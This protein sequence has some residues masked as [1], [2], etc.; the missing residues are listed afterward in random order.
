MSALDLTARD[1]A[2]AVRRGEVTPAAVAADT[3]ARAAERNPAINAICHMNPEFEAEAERVTQRL[4]AGEDPPLAGVP[5]LIKD[6]IWVKGLRVSQGSR[7]FADHIA[8]EDADSVRRLRNAG[9][10][11]LG[12]ATCSEF[13]CKGAT[14]SPHHGITRNPVDLTLGPGGSS[15]GSV[16][17]VAAGIVPLALGTDAGGSSRR[18]PAHTGL[19]GMKPTYD[20]I[21]YGPSFPEPVWGISVI[22][23]IARDMGDI[24]LAMEVMAGVRAETPAMLHIAASPDFGTGQV[25]EPDVAQNFAT[26]IAAFAKAGITVRPAEIDWGGIMGHDI[27]PLQ[28]AGLAQAYGDVWRDTPEIFDP[29]IAKQIETGLSLSGVDVARAHQTSYK[30]R[31]VLRAALDR[32]GIIATP[33]TPCPAWPADLSAPETI[34]GKPAGPRDHAA[35]TPQ[36]NH[37]GVPAL[38]LP[39]GTDRNG[40]PL[41]LQLIAPAGEDGALI[42]AALALEP[43]LKDIA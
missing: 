14:N 34:A 38:S 42:G 20:L 28:F 22:C 13:A 11:I 26:V 10:M 27:L 30:M 15:G 39:C 12:I 6:N 16:A 19:C 43:L 7:L 4:A 35:F 21:P 8:P 25:V 32:Y 2:S 31:M 24:A 3:L 36:V 9:A 41:G 5:V 1:L 33:T 29:M 17:A 18:P 37:A 40:L 23:P